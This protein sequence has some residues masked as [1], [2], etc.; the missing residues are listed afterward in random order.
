ME[1]KKNLQIAKQRK[2]NLNYDRIFNQG[3]SVRNGGVF[4]HIRILF[5][6]KL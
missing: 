2:T 6:N 3:V 4:T 5:R 1:N